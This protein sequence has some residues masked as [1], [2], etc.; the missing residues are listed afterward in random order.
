MSLEDIIKK[1]STL[2]STARRNKPYEYYST[3]LLSLDLAIGDIRGIRGGIIFQLLADQ[4]SGKSTTGL[5]I[6]SQSQCKGKQCAYIDLERTFDETYAKAIGVD[7]DA[8]LIVKTTYAETALDLVQ[9]LIENGVQVVVID[10]IPAGVT[11][12]ERD[13]DLTDNE[14]MASSAGLWGR[15]IKR[16]I[17]IVS[18]TDS[19]L[20]LINQYRANISPMARSD[21][22]P[23]GALAIQYFS[24]IILS[25]ARI[26]NED[27]K[28]T[29][30]I[31]V[32]KNKQ[33]AEGRKT[34]VILKHGLG[35]DARLDILSL[36]IEYGII[37]QK[38]AGWIVYGENK[39]QG[40]ESAANNLPLDEIKQKIIEKVSI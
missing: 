34:E 23:Y 19:L 14:K 8:L 9:E 26:K 28:S 30:Q 2:I 25:L 21:K 15:F 6:I 13:K 20:V 1:H 24:S 36:A 5:S 27:G 18:D 40:L 12:S 32:T 29:V 3:G 39:Y 22:K 17:P 16:I 35:F 33:S 10:S 7:I 38:K 4:K 37:E 31:V 11:S